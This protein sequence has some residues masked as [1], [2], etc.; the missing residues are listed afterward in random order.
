M[1]GHTLCRVPSQ[2]VSSFY[3][4][5][6]TA[7]EA[8]GRVPSHLSAQMFYL[9]FTAGSSPAANLLRFFFAGSILRR[10]LR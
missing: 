6:M 1:S 3:R 10:L 5:T 9:G 8:P 4:N 7:G 2:L